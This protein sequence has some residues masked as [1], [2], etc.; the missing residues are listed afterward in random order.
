MR[1]PWSSG[2]LVHLVG[3]MGMG[4][5]LGIQLVVDLHSK[6]LPHHHQ[7]LSSKASLHLACC[8][9]TVSATIAC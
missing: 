6:R 9:R 5:G 4:V 7:L 3:V 8:Y 2:F 1:A